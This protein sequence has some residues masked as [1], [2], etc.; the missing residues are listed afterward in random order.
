[1]GICFKEHKA[2]VEYVRIVRLVNPSELGLERFESLFKEAKASSRQ[3]EAKL[4]K[5]N[6]EIYAVRVLEDASERRLR[7]ELLVAGFQDSA[8]LKYLEN[9]IASSELRS[10]S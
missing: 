7:A 2:A 5:A 3:T 9:R 6:E 8:R 4:A 10:W 1:M